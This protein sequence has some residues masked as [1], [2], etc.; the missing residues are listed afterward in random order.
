VF[1]AGLWY[2]LAVSFLTVRKTRDAMSALPEGQHV[3]VIGSAGIDVKA[4]P[5]EKLAPGSAVPGLIR[6][7]VGGVARNIAENLARLEVP[8]VLL[9]AVGGDAPGA[10]VLDRCR[11]AGVNVSRALVI[12]EARTGH[13]VA[14]LSAEGRLDVAISD[15]EITR[16]LD[17]KYLIKN[18][19][20]F[21]RAA[22]IVIDASLQDTALKTLFRL[23]GKYHRRVCADPTSP[24]LAGRLAPYLDRIE[25]ITPNLVEAIALCGDPCLETVPVQDRD[26]ALASAQ[27]LLER[28]VHVAAVTIG[29]NGVVYASGTDR[30]HIPAIRTEIVDATG[31]GDAFTSAAIF[32]LLND[33]PLDEALRLGV[34]AASLTLHSSETV[35]PNLSLELL[36]SQLVI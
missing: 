18:R 22:L 9:T 2:T 6:D 21:A 36:Y 35:L 5:A 3:L 10:R 11:D 17:S 15:Y 28:G 23:A 20:Y 32:G 19:E 34:S 26:T 7:S 29:V 30:G 13:Y 27:R 25:M 31:A 33:F 4:R 16:Q 24:V 1:H 12:P 8:T 14:L